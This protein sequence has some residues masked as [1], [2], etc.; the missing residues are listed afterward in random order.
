[1]LALGQTVNLHSIRQ[2]GDNVLAANAAVDFCESLSLLLSMLFVIVDR[3]LRRLYGS[4]C[5]PVPGLVFSSV[6]PYI[7]HQFRLT[8]SQIHAVRNHHSVCLSCHLLSANVFSDCE[9]VKICANHRQYMG[10]PYG[11]YGLYGITGVTYV[12]LSYLR[13]FT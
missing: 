8:S 2:N 13:L 10:N 3:Q 5:C 9:N 7:S 4:R 11:H 6:E 12:P 1:M